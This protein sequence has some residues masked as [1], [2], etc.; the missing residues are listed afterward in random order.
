MGVVINQ[1]SGHLAQIRSVVHVDTFILPLYQA[2]NANNNSINQIS[3]LYGGSSGSGNTQTTT[4]TG[5]IL[6]T[7][8]VYCF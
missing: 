8:W 6:G 2:Y 1:E 4:L 5:T 3:G 7:Q